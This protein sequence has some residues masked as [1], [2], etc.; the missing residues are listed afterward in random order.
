MWPT[1][2]DALIDEQRRLAAADP[3]AWRPPDGDLPIAGCFVCFGRDRDGLG[4]SGDPAWSAA[5]LLC[6][7]RHLAGTVRA[8]TT[9]GPYEPGLL[10]LREG[11]L[12][13]AAVRD[14]PA[15][16]APPPAVLLV[17]ATGRDHPRR[18]GL[19]LHLG[20]VLGLPTV[21]VTHRPLL[22]TAGVNSLPQADWPP[23]RYGAASPLVIDGEEVGCWLRT[24]AGTRPL[25]VHAG[26][27]TSV[28]VAAEVVLRSWC[29]RR[30]PEPLRQARHLARAARAA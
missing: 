22:A 16:P 7:R 5:V 15:R 20:A 10:A 4:A 9:S 18:A 24:R 25:A 28:D 2:A 13:E 26:W 6:G 11:P 1:Q 21:G 14:L 17:N 23:D 29:R 30:T 3:P 8:G 19:A 12:L 27:R